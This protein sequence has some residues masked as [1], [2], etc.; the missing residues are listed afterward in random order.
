MFDPYPTKRERHFLS[1]LPLWKVIDRVQ[2]ICYKKHNSQNVPTKIPTIQCRQTS[3]FCSLI[4]K[5]PDL[6]VSAFTGLFLSE[7]SPSSDSSSSFGE[8]SLRCGRHGFRFRLLRLSL[9]L[10]LLLSSLL[11]GEPLFWVRLE[12]FL[13][14]LRLRCDD[15]DVS[16]DLRDLLVWFSTTSFFAASL[17]SWTA[18]GSSSWRFTSSFRSLSSFCFNVFSVWT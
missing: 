2:S 10:L 1:R 12:L 15:R 16:L 18:G 7:E 8:R 5:C 6:V 3:K 13:C 9:S 11:G 14:W 4:R 17:F